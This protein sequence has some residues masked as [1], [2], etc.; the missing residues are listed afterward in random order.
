MKFNFIGLFVTLEMTMQQA[1]IFL[2]SN[3][4]LK[5]LKNSQVTKMLKQI[6]SEYNV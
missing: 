6:L 4:L 1:S 5:R 3:I 2:V